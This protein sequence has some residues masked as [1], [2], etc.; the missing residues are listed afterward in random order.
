[1]ERA[2]GKNLNRSKISKNVQVKVFHRDGWI[3]R[4]CGRPV[5]FA[6]AMKYLERFVRNAGVTEA[7]AY[8]DAH[9]TRRSAPLLD[10]M[11]AVIDHVEA[12]RRGGKDVAENLA[13]AC[14]KCN[15]DKSDA[16]E[17]EFRKKS[18]RHAVKGKYGE[19]EHWD[20]LSMLFVVLV[21][22]SPKT[23]TPSDR[24]WLRALKGSAAG[25]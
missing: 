21:E 10:Y 3:C 20:G 8:H 18:P 23:A 9:W 6:P 15:A 25:K 11:G 16:P 13:T 22:Q 7:L 12:H 1:M 14:N 24:D 4:W 17:D 5:I 2:T 19:P